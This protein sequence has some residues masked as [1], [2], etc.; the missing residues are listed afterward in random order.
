MTTHKLDHLKEAK[1]TILPKT[2]PAA[3][4]EPF[5]VD[6]WVRTQNDFATSKIIEFEDHVKLG[7]IMDM[8][9]QCVED[10]AG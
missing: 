9:A 2:N 10:I 5:K 3:P 1:I 6:V 7:A 4:R 8:I